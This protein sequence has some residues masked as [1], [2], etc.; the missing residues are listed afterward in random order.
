MD[1]AP[2][3]GALKLRLRSEYDTPGLLHTEQ[4]VVK[5]GPQ[6]YKTATLL[7]FGDKVTGEVRKR[8]LRVQTWRAK[9]GSAGYEFDMT[10]NAWHCEDEIDRITALLLGD[11]RTSG[12]YSLI[13]ADSPLIG[14]AML[15]EQ[16]YVDEAGMQQ[17]TG[18]IASTPEIVE[19]LAETNLTALMELQRHE[20]GL[21]RLRQVVENASSTEP[22]IQ[23]V[24]REEWWVFGGRYI[25]PA[26]RRGITLLDQFDI[27]LIRSDGSLHIVEIKQANLP[28]LIERH[29]NHLIVGSDVHRATSQTI[30]YLRSLDEQRSIISTE[31]GFDCRRSFATVVLG[32]P[33]F[34]SEYTDEE[35]S[36]TIRTYNSHLARIEVITYQDLINGATQALALERRVETDGV[37]DVGPPDS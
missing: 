32:H 20:Q 8:E 14:M 12:N 36:E 25:A 33:M 7:T 22:D 19:A 11:A 4:V 37:D 15:L 28:H 31:L 17:L 29:R 13:A 1:D 9:T 3:I 21:A 2:I 27:P 26:N 23:R 16:G 34:T 6:A 10:A 5:R 35:V 30:N 24:L 18:V